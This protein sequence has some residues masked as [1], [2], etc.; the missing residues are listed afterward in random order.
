MFETSLASAFSWRAA[1][2][3]NPVGLAQGEVVRARLS[4]LCVAGLD[5]GPRNNPPVARRQRG[6]TLIGLLLATGI[7]LLYTSPSPRD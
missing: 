6:E 7:C 1:R 5:A 2:R 4:D 3:S